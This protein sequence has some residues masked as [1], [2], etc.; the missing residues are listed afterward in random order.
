FRP[1][2]GT[3]IA[4]DAFVTTHQ[5]SLAGALLQPREIHGPPQ[6]FT[7]NWEDAWYSIILLSQLTINA[8]ANGHGRPVYGPKLYYG[9]ERLAE[10]FWNIAVPD[11][12]RYVDDYAEADEDGVTFV[13]PRQV[14]NQH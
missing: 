11:H 5:E 9:L 8:A 4:G 1:Y 10:D 3:L 14:N 6:Y 7:P 13:P 12:G 2:D